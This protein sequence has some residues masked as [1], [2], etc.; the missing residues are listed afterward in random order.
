LHWEAVLDTQ[1]FPDPKVACILHSQLLFDFSRLLHYNYGIT[2]SSDF[3]FRRSILFTLGS[4]VLV[5]HSVWV[6][7][8]ICSFSSLRFYNFLSLSFRH[9]SG[10]RAYSKPHDDSY[11]G[12]HGFLTLPKLHFS[13]SCD[14]GIF[15]ELDLSCVG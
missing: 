7:M 3:G 2:F 8:V 5:M 11:V 6:G 13:F 1:V 9:V 10:N 14:E 4:R 15:T 12:F